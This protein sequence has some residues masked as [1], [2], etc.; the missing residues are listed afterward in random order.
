MDIGSQIF[1]AIAAAILHHIVYCPGCN[2]ISPTRESTTSAHVHQMDDHRIQ[3]HI[4]IILELLSTHDANS[5][6]MQA[7]QDSRNVTSYVRRN[8]IYKHCMFTCGLSTVLSTVKYALYL[9]CY[10]G[11]DG[12]HRI[13]S[14]RRC[15]PQ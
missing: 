9:C 12:R 5:Y 7:F 6:H 15:I 14:G 4:N 2:H 3:Q 8:I 13:V 10:S 11:V 1:G